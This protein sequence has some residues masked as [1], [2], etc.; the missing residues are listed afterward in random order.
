L[1]DQLRQPVVAAVEEQGHAVVIKLV[2]ELDLYN[3]EEVR[4]TLDGI[5]SRRPA[6]VVVD[7]AGVSFIDST[8]LGVLVEA[9]S[10]LADRKAFLLS[11]PQPETRRAFEIS[12]LAKHMPIFDRLEDALAMRL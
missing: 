5:C 3:A 2:G 6:R 8:G 12:G 9:R 11:A 4:T 10:K 7:L 1:T